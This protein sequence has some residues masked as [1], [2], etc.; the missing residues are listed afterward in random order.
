MLGDE[1]GQIHAQGVN[2]LKAVIYVKVVMFLKDH[3]YH[4]LFK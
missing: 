3:L 1:K 4:D 2:P